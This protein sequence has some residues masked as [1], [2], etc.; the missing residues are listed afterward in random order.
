MATWDTIYD[1]NIK[2]YIYSCHVWNHENLCKAVIFPFPLPHCGFLAIFANSS[3]SDGKILC[4][5]I[6]RNR[7]PLRNLAGIRTAFNYE[8]LHQV[9][10][11]NKWKVWVYFHCEES[12]QARFFC[13]SAQ[14][15]CLKSCNYH[16]WCMPIWNMIQIS[17]NMFI[18][19]TF[20]I[21]KIYV[22]Q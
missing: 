5:E 8:I 22:K 14:N 20:E 21:M 1:T 17:K 16:F 9:L 15:I 12:L 13:F 7:V 2:K 4:M 19:A 10:F 6:V 18:H 11:S 3:C